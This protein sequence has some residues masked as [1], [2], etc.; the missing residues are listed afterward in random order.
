[1]HDKK[2]RILSWLQ[3]HNHFF[4]A[5]IVFESHSGAVVLKSFADWETLG[6]MGVFGW[7]KLGPRMGMSDSHSDCLVGESSIPILIP[8]LNE[9]DP[10]PSK[11]QSE[12]S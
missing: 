6:I 8:G 11:I 10:I 4:L 1:M 5:G 12:L 7:E 9:N 3:F 2:K